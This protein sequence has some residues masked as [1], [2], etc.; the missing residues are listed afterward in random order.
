[1]TAKVEK[2]MTANFALPLVQMDLAFK[3]QHTTKYL[4]IVTPKVKYADPV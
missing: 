2:A 4:S 3:G 1:M